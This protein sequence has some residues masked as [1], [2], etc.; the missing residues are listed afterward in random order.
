MLA[1]DW[2]ALGAAHAAPG[3]PQAREGEQR[4]VLVKR[5]PRWRLARLGVGIFAKRCCRHD[6]A[7]SLAEPSAP[8]R[9]SDVADIRDRRAAELRRPRHA[10]AG[11]N[12]LALAV[13][14][15]ANDR[16]HLVGKDPR[17]QR[18]VA[19]AI[20]RRA[21]PIADRGL[22]FG[23]TVEV[24]HGADAYGARRCVHKNSFLSCSQRRGALR[25]HMPD[26]DKLTPADPSDLAESIA[27]ALRFRGPQA[28]TR[29]R[30]IHGRHCRGARRAPLGAGRVRG[31][32]EAAD[33]RRSG[34]RAGIRGLT[35]HCPAHGKARLKVAAIAAP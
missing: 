12:K 24:A 30:R 23:Q 32:E 28:K 35:R 16:R 8:V 27:F 1:L 26:V 18:Q 10:P 9:A 7:V 14:P 29:R 15:V 25:S 6:A 3:R 17:K 22:S 4:P 19:S 13:R 2:R 21:K 20:M 11:H 33:R 31:H 5:E 34:A